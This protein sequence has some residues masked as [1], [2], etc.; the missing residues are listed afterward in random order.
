MVGPSDHSPSA[1]FISP[2]PQVLH[3]RGRPR[4]EWPL[5]SSSVQI[6]PDSQG[7]AGLCSEAFT[8][9]PIDPV[10][11]FPVNPSA[12]NTCTVTQHFI[13]SCFVFPLL[14]F[15][16]ASVLALQNCT[17]NGQFLQIP[18]ILLISHIKYIALSLCTSQFNV[19]V[20][21]N[22]VATQNRYWGISHMKLN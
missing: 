1:L 19:W 12:L 22:T 14:L 8:V 15:H 3:P 16:N 17:P 6:K 18:G 11:H 10:F 5:L 4:S 21:E 9:A 13:F 20:K 2:F 7:Q